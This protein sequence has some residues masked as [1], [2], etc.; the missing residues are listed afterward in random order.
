[1]SV[2]AL[3]SIMGRVSGGILVCADVVRT[4]CGEFNGLARTANS[5]SRPGHGGSQP[6]MEQGRFVTE[7]TSDT[8]ETAAAQI[9]QL[10]LTMPSTSHTKHMRHGYGRW[11]QA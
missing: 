5:D 3:E 6:I 2:N 10:R 11:K 7:I 9:K 8:F 4:V 1:M